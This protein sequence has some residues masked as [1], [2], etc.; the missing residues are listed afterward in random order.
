MQQHT[1]LKNSLQE[2]T[3]QLQNHKLVHQEIQAHQN[4]VEMVCEKAQTLVNQTQDKTLNVYIQ[5][6]QTLFQ[7]I[8]LKSRDLQD[9]LELCVHDHAQFNSLCKGFGDWLNLQRDQLHL[10]ADVSGE[11]SDLIKK[12]DNLKRVETELNTCSQLVAVTLI[13]AKDLDAVQGTG[14]KKLSELRTL[15]EK[16]SLSTSERGGKALKATVTSMED[17]WNQHLA[18]VGE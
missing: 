9:K 7:N 15:G 18:K 11:K 8:V 1:E 6:I 4:L 13:V 16:V 3:A 5:S 17:A 14:D 2:K 10:C 12:L